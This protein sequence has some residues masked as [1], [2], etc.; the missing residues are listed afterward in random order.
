MASGFLITGP[1]A[2]LLYLPIRSHKH[3]DDSSANTAEA[4]IGMNVS[5]SI[6]LIHCHP[7]ESCSEPRHRYCVNCRL[8]ACLKVPLRMTERQLYVDTAEQCRQLVK[9]C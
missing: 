8:S 7:I 3:A 4:F 6:F 5:L 9:L 1:V 2:S